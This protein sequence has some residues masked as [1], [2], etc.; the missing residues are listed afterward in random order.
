MGRD[1]SSR[2]AGYESKFTLEGYWGICAS[3]GLR[4]RWAGARCVIR[5]DRRDD[6]LLAMMEIRLAMAMKRAGQ[7][8]GQM[9]KDGR[10]AREN[11]T[12]S[13][14]A[15]A[16]HPQGRMRSPRGRQTWFVA[17][18]APINL[19]KG[20]NEA[21]ASNSHPPTSRLTQCS[22]MISPSSLSCLPRPS[23]SMASASAPSLPPVPQ[24][25]SLP[26]YPCSPCPYVPP[27]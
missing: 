21:P 6:L 25:P 17:K 2:C 13:G 20:E 19:T 16:R 22:T 8:D 1:W 24:Q 9:E 11:I 10:Q 27:A 3:Q 15:E 7:F 4:H 26:A 12:F 18:E 14:T 23:Q 5:K